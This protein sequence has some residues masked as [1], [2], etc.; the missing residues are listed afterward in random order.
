MSL[1]VYVVDFGVKHSTYSQTWKV[2]LI[3]EHKIDPEIIIFGSSVG[4]AGID[5][6]ILNRECG[7]SSFNC[8]IDGTRF[9]Q[10]KGLIDEYNA[11]SVSN[12]CVVMVETYFSFEPTCSLTSI[13]RYAAHIRNQRIYNALVAVQ[14]DLA[15]KC[16]YIPFYKLIAVSHVYYKNAA[17]GWANYLK[18]VDLLNG[19]SGQAP[20][21][22]G[23]DPDQD[24]H[25]KS[26]KL[27]QAEVNDRV[28]QN[29][30]DAIVR[31]AASG[32]KVVLVLPPFYQ[33][34]HNVVDFTLM[35]ET[36]RSLST[37][38]NTLFLDY[39]ESHITT[40]KQNFYNAGHLN[41]KGASTFSRE[42]AEGLMRNGIGR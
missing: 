24:E 25:L 32:R 23:W 16:R 2:N 5:P 7:L 34:M 20:V 19:S 21:D 12:K 26:M 42:L 4:E 31:I 13:E 38:S 17:I 9:S 3:A 29:Y 28:L 8:C 39:S 33:E 6:L 14:P 36:L 40:E 22:R 30:R 18:G 41:R 35:R 1:F 37:N 10:Y 15:W 27:F 11:Y